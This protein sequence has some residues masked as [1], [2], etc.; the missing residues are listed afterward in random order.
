MTESELYQN[1]LKKTFIKNRIFHYR[2]EHISLPDL[3]LYKKGDVLWAELKCIN[4]KQKLIRPDWRTG[5]LAWIRSHEAFGPGHTCLILY[6]C[7]DILFLPAQETYTQ[8]EL[9]CQK[10]QYLKML[11]Q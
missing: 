1:H 3:Y 7:G 5:Q 11:N 2:V 9:L 10:N 8:G 4:E 6:Y